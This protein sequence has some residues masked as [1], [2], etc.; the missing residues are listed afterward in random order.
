M[1][2]P[3]GGLWGESSRQTGQKEQ[4]LLC[5]GG[6]CRSAVAA[7]SAREECVRGDADYQ[8]GSSQLD[9]ANAKE[10]VNTMEDA[11]NSAV[12]A[13]G[14]LLQRRGIIGRATLTFTR[15]E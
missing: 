3:L 5:S 14:K 4:L 2:Q 12:Q 10:S 1:T 6:L 13:G 15:S 11:D 8:Q 9:L 7:E